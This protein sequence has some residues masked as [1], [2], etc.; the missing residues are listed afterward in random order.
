MCPPV[1]RIENR[2]P[3]AVA[4]KLSSSETSISEFTT[5]VNVSLHGARVKARKSWIP[6]ERVRVISLEGNLISQARV[7]YCQRLAG[8]SFA[9]GLELLAPTGN[10]TFPA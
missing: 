9:V 1:G 4:V 6:N 8:E 2:T 10:W 7:V 3:L 5:T